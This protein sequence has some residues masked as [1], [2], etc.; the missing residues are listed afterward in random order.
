MASTR[1]IKCEGQLD[2]FVIDFPSFQ[3]KH[4]GDASIAIATVLGRQLD[5]T[6]HQHRFITRHEGRSALRGTNL[7]EHFARPPFRN[8][9]SAQ[10]SPH[11]SNGL[12]ALG[13]AQ[14]FPEATSRRMSLSKAISAT[15]FLSRAFSRS[16]SR[17]RLA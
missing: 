11:M 14:K 2:A 13:W 7:A 9:R 1:T 15:S 3:A 10:L 6:L 12:A 17:K 8:L 5:H 4:R 16:S